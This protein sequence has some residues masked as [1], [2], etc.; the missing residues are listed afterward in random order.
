MPKWVKGQSGNPKGRERQTPLTDELRKQIRQKTVNGK[1]THLAMIVAEAIE[2]AEVGDMSAMRL[3]WEYL[4]GKPVQPV[5]GPDG[6]GP[7]E[8]TITIAGQ[9]GDSDADPG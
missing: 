1:T 5:A 9:H 2:R 3:V 7:V 6:S 8:F 4:E